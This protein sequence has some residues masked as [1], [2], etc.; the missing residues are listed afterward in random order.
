VFLFVTQCSLGKP[1]QF[2][3]QSGMA[4]RLL[5]ERYLRVLELQH[6]LQ[7]ALVLCFRR[8][9]ERVPRL[10]ESLD[11]ARSPER[12]RRY[13]CTREGLAS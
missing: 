11:E 2:A 8:R 12:D 13:R 7:D 4:E 6:E 5:V 3:L 1:P 9:G 10:Q